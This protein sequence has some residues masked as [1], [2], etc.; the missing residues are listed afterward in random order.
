MKY[1]SFLARIDRAR[2]CPQERICM[3]VDIYSR[4]L[5][6]LI[7]RIKLIRCIQY[8]KGD[9]EKETVLQISGCTFS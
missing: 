9:M 1:N 7:P 8:K 4:T 5:K 6:S 2:Y 3:N